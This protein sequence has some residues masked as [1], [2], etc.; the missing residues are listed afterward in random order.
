VE[1][2]DTS[3][4]VAPMSRLVA[5]ACGS[6]PANRS[7]IAGIMGRKAGDTTAVVLE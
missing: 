2:G 1:R 3:T 4:S 7:A 5:R 6:T